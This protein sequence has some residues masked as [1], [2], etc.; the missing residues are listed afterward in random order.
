MSTEHV[1]QHPG[2]ITRAIDRV[3]RPLFLAFFLMAMSGAVFVNPMLFAAG[4]IGFSLVTAVHLILRRSTTPLLGNYLGLGRYLRV[5]RDGRIL[6]A[7]AVIIGL[8]AVNARVNLLIILLGLLLGA[9]IISGVISESTLRRLAIKVFLPSTAFANDPFPA[10]VSITNG[11]RF[12]PSYSL[13][14]ELY[15]EGDGETLVSKSYILKV[16]AGRTVTLEHLINIDVRGRK[17]VRRVR[18]GTQFPFG[19]FE[20]WSFVPVEAEVLMFPALGRIPGR[21]IPTSDEYRH[22]GATKVLAKAG[23]D[24]FWGIREFR[25]GDNPRHIHWR[26]TARLGKRL[27]KEF[28]R[29]ET[30]N[31]CI[32]LDAHSPEETDEMRRRFER[33]VS[34]AGTLS[35]DLIGQE[36][37][38]SFAA[39][40][41][42]LVKLPTDRGVRQGRRVL[43]ALA[44][45]QP[46]PDVSF[47]AMVGA[48]EARLTAGAFVVA[49]MLDSSRERAAR[50]RLQRS[51]NNRLRVISV[52]TPGFGSLFEPPPE[53][54]T[55]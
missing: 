22:A 16:P 28:H 47:E 6:L 39:H 29:E 19:L 10:R 13:H 12:F 17:L 15:F 45:I 51:W 9:I 44:E 43:T 11:K 55:A 27:V 42:S 7:L 37:G 41:Q 32:L 14:L 52:D 35:R 40:G 36:Y 26:S 18:V 20:K 21:I 48:L 31:I 53:G 2:W 5:T 8:A 25:E 34:F 24:E 4:T 38:L 54:P 1:T 23:R 30:Q 50:A 33:A 49:V 46:S 3:K